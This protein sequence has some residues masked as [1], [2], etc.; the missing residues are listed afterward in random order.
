MGA[1]VAVGSPV[2]VGEETGDS[3][4]NVWVGATVQVVVGVGVA[5][6]GRVVGSSVSVGIGGGGGIGPQALAARA[7]SAPMNVQRRSAADNCLKMDRSTIGS[8]L[9][10]GTV[11][12]Y[13]TSIYL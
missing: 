2:D 10:P 8:L 7:S 1:R 4:G 9:T 12:S 3:A 11:L 6:V 13:H 5:S